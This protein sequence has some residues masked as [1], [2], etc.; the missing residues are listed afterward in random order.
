MKTGSPTLSRC[1]HAEQGMAILAYEEREYAAAPT[2]YVKDGKYSI[3]D[4]TSGLYK[5]TGSV[6]SVISIEECEAA[7][8]DQTGGVEQI[9][10]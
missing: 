9:V 5:G 4:L 10:R 6:G 7:Q 3:R 2:L 1:R 8:I